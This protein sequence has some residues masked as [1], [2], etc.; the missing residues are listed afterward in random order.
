M[1]A[2]WTLLCGL[3]FVPTILAEMLPLAG[4]LCLESS[5]KSSPSELPDLTS[6]QT[7]F[8]MRTSLLIHVLMLPHAI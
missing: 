4:I 2:W 1:P 7:V 6:S 8:L 5:L 3:V